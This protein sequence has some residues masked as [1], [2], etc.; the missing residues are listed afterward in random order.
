MRKKKWT[1]AVLGRNPFGVATHRKPSLKTGK[2]FNCGNHGH[3]TNVYNFKKRLKAAF[4]IE[5]LVRIAIGIQKVIS[6]F[7]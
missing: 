2:C 7:R 1:L 4:L 6:L 5:V 3:F